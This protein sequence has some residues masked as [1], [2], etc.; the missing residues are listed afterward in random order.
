[1]MRVAVAVL[2][3]SLL[4]GVSASAQSD[5]KQAPKAKQSDSQQQS[6]QPS[7]GS[8]PSARAASPSTDDPDDLLNSPM[9]PLPKG[10][11]DS[12][13]KPSQ[14]DS[15]SSGDPDDLLNSPLTPPSSDKPASEQFP[16][17]ESEEKGSYSSSKDTKGDIT[18]P[19]G[20]SLHPG[21]DITN[22]PDDVQETR[23]WNPHEADKDVE[24]GTF[25]F[26]R[27][28]YKGAEARFRDAL[29]WQDN[30]AEATYRLGETLQKEGRLLEARMYYE[31]YLKILPKG[32]FAEASR[33]EIEKMD[34]AEDK[35]EKKTPKKASTSPSL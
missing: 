34:A 35:E 7:S 6:S 10:Q 5:T 29:K 3:G 21:A 13:K 30:H 18:P 31:Q 2:I 32:E 28:N 16:F 26:K 23:P 20:D 8:R 15:S 12:A 14:A 19:R 1:M 27:G 25:Y 22:S 11:A 17:P 9:T 33:R 4:F 24:V